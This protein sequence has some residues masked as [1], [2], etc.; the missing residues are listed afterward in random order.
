MI[1]IKIYPLNV[2]CFKIYAEA[3]LHMTLSFCG[4]KTIPFFYCSLMS[5]LV[6]VD[7]SDGSPSNSEDQVTIIC[8]NK[9]SK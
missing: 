9:R 7:N 6:A 4:Q 8:T 2:E 3:P 5:A 1:L